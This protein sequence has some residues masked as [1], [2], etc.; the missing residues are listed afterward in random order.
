MP[1][2][3]G[4]HN[5]SDRIII[6]TDKVFAFPAIMPIIP[7]HVLI[8]PKRRVD[9]WE[10]L[11]NDEMQSILNLLSAIKTALKKSFGATGFNVAWNEGAVAGQTVDHLHIHVIP[12]SPNDGSIVEYEP[13]QFLYRPGIRK[14][15]PAEELQ[16]I[17]Q[18]I[19]QN[20]PNIK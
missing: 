17:A 20:L 12:R 10:Q 15:S 1:A 11:S 3:F 2:L 16:A 19:A 9:T 7:G 4:N 13:R 14:A 6:E 5:V 18:K 8:C